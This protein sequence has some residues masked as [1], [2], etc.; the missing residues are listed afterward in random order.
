MLLTAFGAGKA[1]EPAARSRLGAHERAQANATD[2]R[3]ASAA[4]RAMSSVS[5]DALPDAQP[6]RSCSNGVATTIPRLL[7]TGGRS[8]I[9]S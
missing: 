8:R 9:L 4:K 7:E 1:F 3:V 5:S 6:S 2:V